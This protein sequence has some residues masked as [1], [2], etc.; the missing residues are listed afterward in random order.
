M[1]NNQH[2][3]NKKYLMKHLFCAAAVVGNSVCVWDL[4]SYTHW[5]GFSAAFILSWPSSPSFHVY[6]NLN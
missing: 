6:F 4:V 2:L 1:C 3:E 5:N